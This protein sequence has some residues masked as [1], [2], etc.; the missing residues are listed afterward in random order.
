MAV[1]KV[2]K[3]SLGALITSGLS[4]CMMPG[5]VH[6]KTHEPAGGFLSESCGLSG[7]LRRGP[8]GMFNA[9]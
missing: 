8:D 4:F 2:E 5:Q 3:S 6:C 1:I 9:L 7:A